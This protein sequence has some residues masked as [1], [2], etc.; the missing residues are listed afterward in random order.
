[1]SDQSEQS[2]TFADLGSR[3]SD[4]ID[5]LTHGVVYP[6]TYRGRHLGTITRLSPFNGQIPAS[7]AE[8]PRV[9]VD[10]FKAKTQDQA[11][12]LREGGGFVLTRNGRRIAVVEGARA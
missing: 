12:R 5:K 6:L 7:V 4:V 2:V 10:T 9:G 1:M 3:P 11:E 8:L